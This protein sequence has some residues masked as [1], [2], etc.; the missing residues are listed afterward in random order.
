[1][2][3]PTYSPSQI[4]DW[5][6]CPRKWG[7]GKIDRLPRPQAASAAFG[8]VVHDLL[9]GHLKGGPIPFHPGPN[10]S[11]VHALISVERFHLAAELAHLATAHLPAPNAP[12]LVVEGG[13]DLA[14]S[15]GLHR[16]TGRIDW[17]QAIH[18]TVTIGDH[19]T[20][21]DIRSWGKSAADLR[22]DVQA[23]VYGKWG[24]ENVHTFPLD[25]VHLQW[26]YI[27]TAKAKIVEPVRLTLERREVDQR[28][29]EIDQIA[30]D[31]TR[32]RSEVRS[33]IDL[34]YESASCGKYGGCPFQ[35]RCNLSPLERM[36]SVMSNGSDLF[37]R[38]ANKPGAQAAPPAANAPHALPMAQPPAPVAAPVVQAPPAPAPSGLSSLAIRDASGRVTHA[39]YTRRPLD[40]VTVESQHVMIA[41]AWVRIDPITP[42]VVARLEELAELA[43]THG[44]ETQQINAAT[45]PTEPPA[46]AAPPPA[47]VQAVPVVPPPPPVTHP[48]WA[49][50]G[51][52]PPA[53]VVAP[54]QINPPEFRPPP[55]VPQ[56]PSAPAAPASPEASASGRKCSICGGA[57]HNA[58]TCPGRPIEKGGNGTARSDASSAPAPVQAAPAAPPPAYVPP[59]PP[60]APAPVVQAPPAPVAQ[61]AAPP[62]SAG[63]FALFLGCR[64]VTGW[65]DPVIEAE[66]IFAEARRR[67]VAGGGPGDFG[68]IKY[69]GAATLAMLTEEIVREIPG[70]FAIVLDPRLR[71]A[72][73]VASRLV[74]LARLVV[75]GGV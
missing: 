48:G 21:S 13:M 68:L 27:Q 32:I 70:A 53:P 50:E 34:P 10:P 31:I 40:R 3:V 57:S 11:P 56:A 59:A 19:K 26:T 44:T 64:P 49:P 33:A 17:M 16:W 39:V 55:L 7:F 67:L 18:N 74:A 1:M 72:E 23:N 28:F 42:D 58:K 5:I 22:A 8:T 4:N 2:T 45:A 12:G 6:D 37:N 62:S 65:S 9:E 14:P 46:P 38:L 75:R 30:L 25:S 61:A 29:S 43:A 47:P 54:G 66:T 15:H 36:K 20:T 71:E 69:E 73:I 63:S 35:S 60:S 52:T 51:M 41:G 24:M